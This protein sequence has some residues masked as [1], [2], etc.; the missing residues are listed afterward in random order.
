MRPILLALLCFTFVVF[1]ND[2]PSHESGNNEQSSEVKSERTPDTENQ[3]EE[4]NLEAHGK[5][6]K[7]HIN[8]LR[9]LAK[10]KKLPKSTKTS[11]LKMIQNI[12]DLREQL[13]KDGDKMSINDLQAKERELNDWIKRQM[14]KYERWR[15]QAKQRMLRVVKSR[16]KEWEGDRELGR[17]HIEQL[18][19]AMLMQ[20][21]QRQNM[22]RKMLELHVM[23]QRLIFDMIA[24]M[25]NRVSLTLSINMTTNM[26]DFIARRRAQYFKVDKE[27]EYYESM[28]RFDAANGRQMSFDKRLIN[29]DNR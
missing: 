10:S 9:K 3:V 15:S 26:L 25:K 17:R 14:S 22:L 11:Q 4:P 5:K 12:D 28:K 23:L 19:Q 27:K 6:I 8:K 20:E 13:S 16:T 7:K 24:S 29:G 21:I 1:G 2:Q 18:Y